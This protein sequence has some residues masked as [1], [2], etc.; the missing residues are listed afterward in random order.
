MTVRIFEFNTLNYYK[1]NLKEI[2]SNI[3]MPG[4][5]PSSQIQLEFNDPPIKK[6]TKKLSFQSITNKKQGYFIIEMIGNGI[7]SRAIIRKGKL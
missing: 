2:P 5:I 3:N 4:L 1:K 7:K 6:R